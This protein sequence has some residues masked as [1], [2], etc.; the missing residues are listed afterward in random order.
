MER[1][2]RNCRQQLNFSPRLCSWQYL[3]ALSLIFL[4]LSS[5]VQTVSRAEVFDPG[6]A[7]WITECIDCPR[8]FDR[9]SPRSAQL[10]SSGRPHV[11]F[12]GDHLYYSYMDA[13][14]NWLSDVVDNAPQV[15]L[16]A[17]LGLDS[18]DHPH[19]IYLDEDNHALKYAFYNGTAWQVERLPTGP[20]S[21]PHASLVIGVNDLPYLS[22][23]DNAAKDLMYAFR[24]LSGWQV[25]TVDANG[26]VGQYSS[27][28]LDSNGYPH[29]SYHDASQNRLKYAHFSG[30]EW[31]TELFN[32]EGQSG[33][34]SSLRIDQNDYAHIAYRGQ[35]SGNN[36][37]L[38]Y[39][40]QD[41][42]GWHLE[43][44]D[45]SQLQWSTYSVGYFVSLQLDQAGAPHLSYSSSIH[46][47]PYPFYDTY[48]LRYAYRSKDSWQVESIDAFFAMYSTL[49]IDGPSTPHILYKAFNEL[50]YVIKTGS[51][52]EHTTIDR[53]GL[54]GQ[55]SSLAL[56]ASRKP[57]ISYHDSEGTSVMYATKGATGWSAE[58]IDG[59]GNLSA[60]K[61][62]SL[63]LTGNGRPH[64]LYENSGRMTLLNYVY[65]TETGWT[66][67]LTGIV[68]GRDFDLALDAQHKLHMSFKTTSAVLGYCTGGCGFSGGIE[69][70][71]DELSNSGGRTAIVV[72]RSARA[73][74]AYPK[75]GLR[76]TGPTSSG[77][78]ST[79]V[80]SSPADYVSIALDA[81][82]V[83]HFS[84]Y[85]V[86]S[87]NLKYAY[88]DDG[89]GWQ[90]ET[91]DQAGDV[92]LHTSLAVD[93]RGH[94]HI[95]Y[96]DA[97]NADLKYAYSNGS[98]WQVITLVSDGDVGSHSSLALDLFGYPYIAYHDATLGDLKII[99][100]RFTPTDVLYFPLV[101]S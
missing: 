5:S 9:M 94:V 11:A 48:E 71:D 75:N 98:S 27:I 58:R 53:S 32:D 55:Y 41:A 56:D 79:T 77:W 25:S 21:H 70:I 34:G 23:Y 97:T 88:Q 45:E 52:W 24:N 36:T 47:S 10:D 17:T 33:Y 66:R 86:N 28:A 20:I 43:I 29:I 90:I 15:G 68:G 101:Q 93:G 39:R 14:G 57:H 92:G 87:G 72:D 8:Y 49:L 7:T 19:I 78:S 3:V 46:R 44:A 74:I 31:T 95:S 51:T 38:M 35:G 2:G 83:P 37:A 22:F 73:H 60:D 18:A 96:Y 65:L 91:I 64:I 99:Y 30:T 54:V 50:H 63:A 84:Y 1:Q 4:S 16:Y 59:A 67:T 100:V 6:T 42:E 12:G 26:D 40:Y 13:G 62:T 69:I 89:G 82:G 81:A 85:D 80:D 76:Y 61:T